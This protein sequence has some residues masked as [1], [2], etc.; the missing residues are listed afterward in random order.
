MA[1]PFPVYDVSRRA[2]HASAPNEA[3][4]LMIIPL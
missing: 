3:E 2:A 1:V 4:C